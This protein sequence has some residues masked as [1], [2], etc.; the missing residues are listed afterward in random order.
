MTTHAPAAAWA[1]DHKPGDFAVTAAVAHALAASVDALIARRH[2]TLG[3]YPNATDRDVAVLVWLAG[4]A[5]A[6]AIAELAH[7]LG[8]DSDDIH[9]AM[10]P[11]P[12][13][14]SEMLADRLDGILIGLTDRR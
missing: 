1:L 14:D 3:G 11:Y 5:R 8:V 9:A 13:G 12:E 7:H 4:R 6:E 2:A 10:S